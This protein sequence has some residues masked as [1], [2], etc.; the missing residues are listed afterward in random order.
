[1]EVV[2][3]VYLKIGP[4]V[5][6]FLGTTE[7]NNENNSQLYTEWPKNIHILTRKILKSV[8]IFLGHPVVLIHSRIPSSS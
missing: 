2:V 8:Y 6:S 5:A 1:M 7:D 3:S 4:T